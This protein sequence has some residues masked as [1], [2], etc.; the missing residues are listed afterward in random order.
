MTRSTTKTTTTRSRTVAVPRPKADPRRRRPLTGPVPMLGSDVPTDPDA[1]VHQAMML[2]RST[3]VPA[4]LRGS[5]ENVLALMLV[6]RALQLPLAVVWQN[7]FPTGEGGEVGHRSRL[8]HMLL[9]RAGHRVVYLDITED[10]AD[11]LLW[12]DGAREPIECSYTMLEAVALGLTE[13][14][15]DR[16]G[17]WRRQ[18]ANMLRNRLL[19]RMVDWYLPEVKGGCD[20]AADGGL[21]VTGL[22]EGE[23]SGAFSGLG[24]E[25]HRLLTALER[26]KAI[27]NLGERVT[28]LQAVWADARL[29]LDTVVDDEGARLGDLI[30]EALKSAKAA[31]L[32]A[33]Q[34]ETPKPKRRSRKAAA[35]DQAAVDQA[36]LPCGCNALEAIGKGS[37]SEECASATAKL[38][39]A[40]KGE[41]S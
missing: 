12:I 16:D 38:T 15:R 32:A 41:R 13:D 18:P 27:E 23:E 26:A 36:T 8:L 2:A 28:A 7:V 37:H 3:I 19:S 24:P 4:I 10:R 17:H 29:L 11:G 30:G 1:M 21:L 25:V 20:W 14:W 5:A 33:E 39:R 9:R 35:P 34:G 22:A 31:A 40:A 6:S